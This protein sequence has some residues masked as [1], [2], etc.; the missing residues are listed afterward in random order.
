MAG[1]LPPPAAPH[2]QYHG[3]WQRQWGTWVSEIIIRNTGQC[4]WLGTFQSARKMAWTH[5]VANVQFHCFDYRVLNFPL[6]SEAV[7]EL[8]SPPSH[9][10]VAHITR[11]DR[12]ARMGNK[13]EAA[14][15]RYMA[16]AQLSAKCT[17]GNLFSS[18]VGPSS[19][20]VASSSSA[21]AAS[22]SVPAQAVINLCDNDDSDDS[23]NAWLDDLDD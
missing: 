6:E 9:S 4:H 13:A 15:E 14:G 18:S 16:E 5:K 23:F 17:T 12:E 20:T 22:Y 19:S 21:T 11:E 1:Y 3:V 7:P 2:D 10:R 8:L